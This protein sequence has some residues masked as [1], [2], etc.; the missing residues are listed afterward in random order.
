MRYVVSMLLPLFLISCSESKILLKSLSTYQAPLDYLHDSKICDCDK[1]ATIALAQFDG[2]VFDTATSVSKINHKLPLVIYNFEKLNLAVDLGQ[3][4]LEQNYSDFFK[5]SFTVESQRTGCYSVADKPTDSNYSLEITYD[6][7]SIKSKYQRNSTVIFLL[8]AYSVSVQEVGFP[9]ESNI[10]LNVKL[11]KDSNLIFE[12]RYSVE[13][14]Q[15]FLNTN[16]RDVDRLR[17]DFVTN[18]AESLSF[19]TKAC[20]E[21][22]VAD[23]NRVIDQQ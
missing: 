12:K 14:T 18:M 9:A 20:I 10:A 22:I 1:S 16:Q 7:C 11:K 3:N 19:S 23:I 15:P 8:L 5:K 13:R 2:Q 21:T 17:S 4:S 6:T